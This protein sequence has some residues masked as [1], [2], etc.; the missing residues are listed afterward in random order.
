M[1]RRLTSS[2]VPV[3]MESPPKSDASS[4]ACFTC[5]TIGP[6]QYYVHVVR[7]SYHRTFVM[8]QSRQAHQSRRGC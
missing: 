3:R 8:H 6:G 4:D 1:I 7:R 2:G 5:G